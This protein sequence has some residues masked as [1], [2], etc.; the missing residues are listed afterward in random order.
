M[1]VSKRG[2]LNEEVRLVIPRTIWSKKGRTLT[3]HLW[4]HIHDHLAKL[5]IICQELLILFG[6][7]SHV[8]LQGQDL[9]RLGTQYRLSAPNG[10]DNTGCPQ[11]LDYTVGE[12]V[13]LISIRS[14]WWSCLYPQIRI[15]IWEG[16]RIVPISLPQP[17]VICRLKIK[18]K[19][20]K[21]NSRNN[22][23]Q[24]K[25]FEWT[26]HEVLIAVVDKML[27]PF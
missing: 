7:I 14:T 27:R 23:F 11:V 26:Y 4:S 5:F 3:T 12:S 21:F 2:L 10:W 25:M 15:K 19:I 24:K 16:L 13:Y 6:E 9:L 18:T 22:K 17:V 8:L 1:V 20:S